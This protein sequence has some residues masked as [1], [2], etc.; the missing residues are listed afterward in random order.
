MPTLDHDDDD[1][2]MP[3]IYTPYIIERSSRGE[4]TYDI[5]SRLLIDRI[6]FLGTPI[7]DDVANIIIAQMLFL[8][9]DNPGKDINVYINS[10][11]G[12]VSAGL[13]I[14]DTMQ[15]LSSPV[16]TICMGMA[17]SMGCFLLAGGTKGKRFC[18][19]ARAHHDAPAVGRVAGHGV[20][21]R[22]RRE[23]DPVPPHE[24][25][26]ADGQ[27]H[28]PGHRAHR[29][30]LRPRP[31]H[32]GGRGEGLRHDRP[33]SS[34]R[35]ARS[36]RPRSSRPSAPDAA[37]GRCPRGARPPSSAAGPRVRAR[38]PSSRP[39][40]AIAP[41]WCTIGVASTGARRVRRGRLRP[42]GGAVP[43][44]SFSSGARV[45][46][47]RRACAAF[48][49]D[50]PRPRL[51]RV[52][53]GRPVSPRCSPPPTVRTP[54]SPPTPCRTTNTCAAR[55]AE[56]RRTRSGSSSPDRSVYICNECIALCNEILA[57][58]EEREV[59]EAIT[60]VPTPTEIK[61]VLDST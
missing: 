43:S 17:A 46:A 42:C 52:R 44:A 8:E 53:G 49:L 31:V 6:I 16:S 57:E 1:E 18:A 2:P 24:D 39:P 51:L 28:R 21:H 3:T 27:A 34:R 14:Y 61:D 40:R 47:V 36:S 25:E 30:R 59:A 48:M 60:Q 10:P 45:P 13:A 35:A 12:S 5:F 37:A 23:R 26:R 54:A 7:N 58:D 50:R 41:V 29:A 38:R 15:Y 4:R 20:R 19:A 33:R 56:S 22:D 32:V 11:G 55:S 9:A